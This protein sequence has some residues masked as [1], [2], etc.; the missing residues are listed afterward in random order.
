MK[1]STDSSKIG[2]QVDLSSAT[3]ATINQLRQSFQIQKLLERD[4]R[5][6][7]RYAEIVNAHFGVQFQDVTYRPEFL[8]GSSTPIQINSVPQTS[9]IN[10]TPHGS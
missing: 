4:A 8:G 2:L 9:E 7:T 6:G 1:F 3:A 10:T 5:S